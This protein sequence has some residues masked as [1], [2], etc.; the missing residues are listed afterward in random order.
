[1]GKQKIFIH[2][3]TTYQVLGKTKSAEQQG[4][5]KRQGELVLAYSLSEKACGPTQ[6]PEKKKIGV[7]RAIS[8]LGENRGMTAPTCVRGRRQEPEAKFEAAFRGD[9]GD[10]LETLKDK[11]GGEDLPAHPGVPAQHVTPQGHPF[12]LLCCLRATRCHVRKTGVIF[13][14]SP[15]S[16][17]MSHGGE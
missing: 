2:F 4:A 6:V 5:S 17:G 1:M 14:H 16:L 15:E 9:H 7:R 8:R 3:S 11:T 10:A 12:A 13:L